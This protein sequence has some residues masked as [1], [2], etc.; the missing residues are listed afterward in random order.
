[1]KPLYDFF[2]RFPRDY[3]QM[4]GRCR[5]RIYPRNRN[6]HTVLL[7]E[8][9]TNAGESISSACER[10]A[11]DLAVTK[12]LNP[13]TTRWIQHDP[14]RDDQPEVCDEVQF[15]WDGDFTASDPQWQRLDD[16]QIEALTGESLSALSRRLGDPQPA[17]DAVASL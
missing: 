9:S 13:K 4:S 16:E 17:D 11:T 15:T 3:L 14:T 2:Y 8:L 5:V 6:A 1:M 12:R 7:T 10:I